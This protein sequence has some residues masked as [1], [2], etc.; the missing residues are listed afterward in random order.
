MSMPFAVPMVWREPR[1]N[2]D[3]CY[4]C[5]INVIGF[6][7]QSKH[8]TEYPDIPSASRPVRHDVSMPVPEPPEEY[9]LDSEPES[10]EDLPEAGISTR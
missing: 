10:E 6:F 2:L 9:T 7:V 3:D 1:N 8:K 4:F 5:I